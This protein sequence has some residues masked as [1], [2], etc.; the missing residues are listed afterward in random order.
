MNEYEEKEL[1]WLPKDLAKK[2]E[3]LKDSDN[4][5]L[6]YIEESKRDIKANLDSLDDEIVQYK[7]LMAK[8]RSSFKEAKE[9]ALEAN[10]AL[11]E[12]FDN[13]RKSL[14]AKAE[15]MV[16]SLK[17]LTEELKKI[18]EQLNNIHV[19]RFKEVID[20][21]DAFSNLYGDKREILEFLL[22]NYKKD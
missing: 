6:K 4:F 20:V 15:Q 3:S 12:S 2:V 16:E 18:N 11:W 9:D 14:K 1:V 19:Y 5:V 22:K 8:A 13:E 17:P 21:I 10:Y 7:G